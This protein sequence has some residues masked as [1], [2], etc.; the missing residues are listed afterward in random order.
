MSALK[1]SL[2]DNEIF[3]KV[4]FYA[5]CMYV[6]VFVFFGGGGSNNVILF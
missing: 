1:F 4:F 3:L 5:L 2:Y 6:Y